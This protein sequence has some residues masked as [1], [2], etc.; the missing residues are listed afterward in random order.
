[1]ITKESSI[2]YNL[3]YACRKIEIACAVGTHIAAT[4][5]ERL[6]GEI[7]AQ[8][9]CHNCGALVA[10]ETVNLVQTPHFSYTNAHFEGYCTMKEALQQAI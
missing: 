5:V 8:S 3:W 7:V 6:H 2:R 4:H 10:D 9:L 1:M